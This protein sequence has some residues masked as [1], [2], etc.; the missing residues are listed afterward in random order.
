LTNNVLVLGA[1]MVSRPMIKY[2][3]NTTD[4][5]IIMASRTVEKAE[6]IISGNPKGK[7]IELNVKD[8]RLLEKLISESDI[9]VSLLPYNH[10]VKVAKYCIKHRKPMVTTSYVSDLMKSLDE[11][12]KKVGILILNECGLDPGIDHMSSMRIIHKI[13]EKEGKITSFKSSTGALPSHE[14]N[15]NPFGYKFSWAPRGVLLASKN[16]SKW[17]EN[18][19]I[20]EYTGE[21]LFENYYIQD[22]S[23]IGSFENYPNRN[24]LP[25]KDIYGLKYAHTVYRGTLR[26]TGWC[27]TMR[28]IVALGWLS[29]EPL[30]NFYGKTYA[31]MTR[32]LIDAKETD[33]LIKATAKFLNL[34]TYSTVIKRLEW[35]GLFS[36]EKLPSDKNNPL[37]YLNIMSLKKMSLGENER[38]MIVMHHEFIV[39][40]P[41]KK[42]YITSTLID[43][44]IICEDSSIARTVS[45][46]AA[47][48]VKMILY[49]KIKLKGVKIPVLPEIYNP[50][51][52]ELK[53]IGIK[54]KEKIQT[55]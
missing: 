45:I 8:E 16:P 18:G 4:F 3:F 17:F 40:Y 15:N 10:H 9:T 34:T 27:E 41:N 52:N 20:K 38:D 30:K 29:E 19:K 26:M 12:A 47:I 55:I 2:F 22:I 46:P 43:Y 51:L 14:A 35:L 6:K 24:S 33:D 44:G 32:T 28:K 25:Y 5:N 39:E 7:S 48:A 53:E 37:D 42:E 13:E 31:D 21:Q 11:K 54:F 23:G 50:I 1:G 36:D 49:G